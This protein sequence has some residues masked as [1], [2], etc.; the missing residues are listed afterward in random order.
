MDQLTAMKVFVQVVESGSFA[1]A[2]DRLGL[3]TSACSRHVADLES[4]LGSRLLNRTTR[5]LSLTESGRAFHERTRQLLDDLDEAEQF[6]AQSVQAPRGTLRVTCSTNFGA[7]HL[8]PAIAEF[9]TRHPTVSF[10]VSLSD[11]VVDIVEEGFDLAVRI[12]SLGSHNHVVRKLAV[13]RMVACASPSYLA[14]HGTPRTPADLSGHNC[15]TYEYVAA[16]DVW[17]FRGP[18]G[19]SVQ[20]RVRGNLHA[21][22]GD[23]L[24]EAAAHGAGIAWEPGFIVDPYVKL[25]RL[26]P[27]LTEFVSPSLDIWAVYPSRRHLSAKVRAFVDFLAER[28]RDLGEMSA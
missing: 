15:F 19:E 1:R 3:S 16:P 25:G 7:R 14:A 2:A 11:R 26:V 21:N 13:S 9:M 12:G 22:S 6:V 20:A 4:H 10:D 18:D 5:K 28:F 27:L 8:S 17:T 23:L 24:V